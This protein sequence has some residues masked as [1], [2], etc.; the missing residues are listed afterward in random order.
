MIVSIL[1]VEIYMPFNNSLKEK[2]RTINSIKDKVRNRFNVSV[3]EIDH[4][5]T[6]RRSTLAF[7]IVSN[8]VNYNNQ[9]LLEI[10]RLL[11]EYT[12]LEI[13]KH[14]IHYF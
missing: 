5:D 14:R 4:Q 8:N 3:A 6:W 7:A 2:R 11:E 13:L 12:E 1:E 10:L 9:K